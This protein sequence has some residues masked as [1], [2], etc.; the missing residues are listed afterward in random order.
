MKEIIDFKNY[1]FTLNKLPNFYETIRV[2]SEDDIFLS[3]NEVLQEPCEK[4][5]IIK[6]VPQYFDVKIKELPK[7]IKWFN[8]E[9][10]AGFL[11]NFKNIASTDQYLKSRFGN[12]S[13]Y[14]LRR[15]I[16]KLE[17]CFDINY[18]MFYGEMSKEAYD[19][20]FD[21]FFRLLEIRSVEKEIIDNENV[22]NQLKI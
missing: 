19:F 4:V 20:I 17:N 1:V 11:I 22:K 7:Y 14:K 8:T 16:K 10:Y 2:S 12:S 5:I 3:N 18:R 9:Q 15:S 6:D 21:E 13:R